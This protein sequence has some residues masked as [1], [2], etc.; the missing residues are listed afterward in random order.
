VVTGGAMRQVF[1]PMIKGPRVRKLPGQKMVNL[2]H[3]TRQEDLLYMKTLIE[4]GQVTP[5]VDRCY[6]LQ[7]TAQALAYYG[8]GHARGKVVIAMTDAEGGN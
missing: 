5:V 3:E 2:S 8:R 7:E 4:A 1:E 6:P